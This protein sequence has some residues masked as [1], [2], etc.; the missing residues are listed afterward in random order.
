MANSLLAA[1]EVHNAQLWVMIK[2][3]CP[4]WYTVAT[5]ASTVACS[6][7]LSNVYSVSTRMGDRQGRP[8]TV[9]LCPFVGVDLNPWSTVYI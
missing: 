8:S 5:K 2:L 6:L 1:E 9:N 4:T 3:Q 7:K